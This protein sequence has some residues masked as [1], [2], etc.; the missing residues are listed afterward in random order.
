MEVPD[1]IVRRSKSVERT[2]EAGRL[3]SIGVLGKTIWFAAAAALITRVR[4]I[5]GMVNVA[6]NFIAEVSERRDL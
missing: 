6:E 3:L 1:S 5:R 4:E 2:F